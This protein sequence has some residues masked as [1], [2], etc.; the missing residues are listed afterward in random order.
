MALFVKCNKV[1]IQK[2]EQSVQEERILNMETE[3]CSVSLSLLTEINMFLKSKNIN[4]W[5]ITSKEPKGRSK[6]TYYILTYVKTD[7]IIKLINF[8]GETG[9]SEA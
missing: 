8:F 6:Q 5:K 2:M 1:L 4:S 3:F 9:F 7:E